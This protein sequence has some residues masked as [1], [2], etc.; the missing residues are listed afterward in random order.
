MYILL[1]YIYIGLK[2][3]LVCVKCITESDDRTEDTGIN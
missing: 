1:T 3:S 2:Y